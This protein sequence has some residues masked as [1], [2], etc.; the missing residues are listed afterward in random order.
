MGVQERQVSDLISKSSGKNLFL[1]L[2]CRYKI[3]LNKEKKQQ[4]KG[5]KSTTTTR[6]FCCCCPSRALPSPPLD[7]VTAG[8]ASAPATPQAARTIRCR[9]SCGISA[10]CSEGH[11]AAH[12]ALRRPTLRERRRSPARG[13]PPPTEHVYHPGKKSVRPLA[14]KIKHFRNS[15]NFK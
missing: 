7:T 1:Q 12:P 10:R 9:S 15:V 11:G 2:F 6:V 3:I 14:T 4:S 13:E 5:K 8:C